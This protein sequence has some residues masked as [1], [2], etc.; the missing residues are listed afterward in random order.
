MRGA[1]DRDIGIIASRGIIP[2]Y[3]GSTAEILASRGPWTDHPRVCG[4]HILWCI[5]HRHTRGSSPRMRGAQVKIKLDKGAFGIIP[6]YAGSTMAAS[7]SHTQK[8]DHPR[9]CGEH[10]EALISMREPSGS[11]P[12]MRGARERRVRLVSEVGIIP[13]YAGSTGCCET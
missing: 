1:L 2:A 13:A 8:R 11:S 4:E 5:L 7:P 12:R 3:A 9:V 6:A 10:C